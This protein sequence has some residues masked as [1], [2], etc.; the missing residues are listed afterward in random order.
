[1]FFN[2][3]HT[4]Q[5]CWCGSRQGMVDVV[6]KTHVKNELTY[7]STN[8]PWMLHAYVGRA[9][10]VTAHGHMAIVHSQRHVFNFAQCKDKFFW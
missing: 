2:F 4:M 9:H 3:D 1:M 8:R 10:K 6:E 7:N 5:R